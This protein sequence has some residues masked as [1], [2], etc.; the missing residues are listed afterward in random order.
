MGVPQARWMVYVIE[1]PSEMDI[2]N[3]III[4]HNNIS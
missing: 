1:N 2:Y 4:Y 3:I